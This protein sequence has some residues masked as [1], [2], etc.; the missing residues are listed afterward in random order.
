MERYRGEVGKLAFV[1]KLGELLHGVLMGDELV[2][3]V[4]CQ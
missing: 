1:T 4:E 3:L 2:I